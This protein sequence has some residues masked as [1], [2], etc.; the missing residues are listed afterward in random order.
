MPHLK[1]LI[2]AWTQ[3]QHIDPIENCKELIYLEIDHCIIRD[4]TPLLGCTALQDINIS[5]AQADASVEPIKQMTWLKNLWVGE[6]SA[7]DQYALIDAL[8]DT[9]VVISN[10]STASGHGWRNLPNYY[11]MRDY[12]GREYMQ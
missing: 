12:L 11:A 5:D 3:V 1:Y 6:R 9:N 10:P 4:Y 2:L 8:P 7:Y